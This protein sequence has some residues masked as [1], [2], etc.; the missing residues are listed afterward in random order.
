M[1]S[2]RGGGGALSQPIR[3]L[4][5]AMA[6]TTLSLLLALPAGRASAQTE[7]L[8]KADRAQPAKPVAID[9]NGVIILV[10]TTLLALDQAN[11][12][13]NYSVLRDLGSSAF[14]ARSAADLA[15]IFANQRKQ[16]LNLGGVAVLEPQL[17]LMPQM[18]ANGLLRMAGFFPSVPMQVNFELLFAA[19]DR[20][21]KIFGMSVNLTSGASVAPETDPPPP[22][23][24]STEMPAPPTPRVNPRRL[25]TTQ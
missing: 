2:R 16:E 4:A 7:T 8:Q 9:R 24:L 20:E 12:T 25:Q 19:E 1:A 5:R 6:A 15:E 21:W 23:P 14:R 18:E 3:L 11:R 13:V 10:R 17:T 22:P